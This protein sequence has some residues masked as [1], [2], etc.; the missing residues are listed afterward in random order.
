[1]NTE[2]KSIR[3]PFVL[4]ATLAIT[5]ISATAIW[6]P[7]V[8]R[9]YAQEAKTETEAATHPTL[10]TY[11]EEGS[12][13]LFDEELK[14]NALSLIPYESISLERTPCFGPCPVYVVT[15]YKD[16]HATL[17][18]NNIWND[19]GKKY[20]TGKIWLGDYIRLAQMV[21]LAKNASTKTEYMAQWTD[22]YTAVIRATSKDQTWVVSDY[23]RVAP[24]EVWALETLLHT[25]REQNE[26]TPA[27]GP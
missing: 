1:M 13:L 2:P 21:T 20:Y 22:D 17:F 19:R 5:A 6:G 16:G 25:F 8:V 9:Q 7:V 23:G 26:W 24:V 3:W 18:T 15:F 11:A 12:S 10:Q 27:S 4:L 14:Q